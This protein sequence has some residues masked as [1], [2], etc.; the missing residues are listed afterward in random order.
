VINPAT[1]E[2]ICHI[3]EAGEQDVENAIQAAHQAY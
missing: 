2:T 3:E 1:E